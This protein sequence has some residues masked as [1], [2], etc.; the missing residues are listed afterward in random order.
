MEIVLL[1]NSKLNKKRHNKKVKRY[2]KNLSIAQI[3]GY[4]IKRIIKYKDRLRK[5]TRPI[6]HLQLEKIRI[7]LINNIFHM[8]I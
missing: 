2:G 1:K 4:K 3:N 6:I 8:Q 5:N 7:L